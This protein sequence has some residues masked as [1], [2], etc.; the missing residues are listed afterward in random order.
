MT[1][2]ALADV[3]TCRIIDHQNMQAWADSLDTEESLSVSH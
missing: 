2:E 3:D 1:R